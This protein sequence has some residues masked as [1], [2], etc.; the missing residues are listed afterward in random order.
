MRTSSFSAQG[1][2]SHQEDRFLIETISANTNNGDGLLL[3][4]MDGHSGS[5]ISELLSKNLTPFFADA[6]VET[7]G[8]LFSTFDLVV[9]E[10]QAM[11]RNSMSG[12]TLS[13]VYIPSHQ[14][15]ANTFVYTSVI[16]DSP[17]IILGKN[18]KLHFSEEHNASVNQKDVDFILKSNK[19]L[20]KRGDFIVS[21]GF[22][23]FGNRYL[24]LTRAFGDRDFDQLI[25]R[26]PTNEKIEIDNNSIIIVASDGIL[27]EETRK[28]IYT[29]AIKKVRQ[30]S[31]PEE[32]VN[33]A[34][35]QESHDNVTVLL[36]QQ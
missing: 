26:E 6:L 31:D 18:N 33:W 19:K 29:E 5:E 24:Q 22:L 2:R 23:C 21:E 34:L 36:Y 1:K 16:G 3:A 13:M 30:G 20:A 12:S 17:I 10:L 25:I 11:T 28:S 9:K 8:K 4:V 27:Y 32:L 14:K 7:A 15:P 35:D